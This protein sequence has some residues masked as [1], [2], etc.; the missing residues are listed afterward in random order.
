MN[1]ELR[2]IQPNNIDIYKATGL[3]NEAIEYLQRN[4]P[5]VNPELNDL[6]MSTYADEFF[7]Y[8]DDT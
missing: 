8:I 1:I 2:G 4:F 6:L 5:P 7:Y 3:S